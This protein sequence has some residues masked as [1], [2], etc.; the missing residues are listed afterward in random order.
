MPEGP[1]HNHPKPILYGRVENVR[2]VE[3]SDGDHLYHVVRESE[4]LIYYLERLLNQVVSGEIG[5]HYSEHDRQ[6]IISVLEDELDRA[7]RWSRY[8]LWSINDVTE[9]QNALSSL[10]PFYVNEDEEISQG[11]TLDE[12]QAWTDQLIRESQQAE[13]RP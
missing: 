7:R 2:P 9:M 5:G 3:I 1:S 13:D 11:M 8:R 10:E 12:W 4:P 6:C